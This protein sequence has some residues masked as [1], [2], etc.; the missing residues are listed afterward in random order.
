MAHSGRFVDYLLNH[1][2]VKPI[3]YEYTHHPFTTQLGAGTLGKKSFQ[4]YL[5]QDYLFL[6]TSPPLPELSVC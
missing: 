2:S 3:W 5:I 1:P 4:H 6:V